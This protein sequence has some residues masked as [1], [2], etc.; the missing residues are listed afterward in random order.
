MHGFI[1][2]IVTDIHTPFLKVAMNVCV[3]LSLLRLVVVRTAMTLPQRHVLQLQTYAMALPQSYGTTTK[4]RTT[5][6][7]VRTRK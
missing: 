7:N 3:W 5:A 6:T 1:L 2:N 4:A